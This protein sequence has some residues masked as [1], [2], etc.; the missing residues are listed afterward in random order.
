MPFDWGGMAGGAQQGLEDLIARQILQEKM[1]L[2]QRQQAAEEAEP[3]KATGELDGAV[4][5]PAAD[6]A[7]EETDVG[8]VIVQAGDLG[9]GLSTRL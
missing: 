4:L 1:A 9:E 8:G 5:Q 7:R 3:G 6:P 2:A